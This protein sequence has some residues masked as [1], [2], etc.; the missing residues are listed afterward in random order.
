MYSQCRD[1]RSNIRR[2]KLMPDAG[3]RVSLAIPARGMCST[4]RLSSAAA[5]AATRRFGPRDYPPRDSSGAGGHDPRARRELARGRLVPQELSICS[6]AGPAGLGDG[7]GNADGSCCA[8]AHGCHES[9]RLATGLGSAGGSAG[10]LSASA[11]R[12]C[13]T[14]CAIHILVGKLTGA[15]TCERVRERAVSTSGKPAKPAKRSPTGTTSK[16]QF[17]PSCREAS[18]H[19]RKRI[20]S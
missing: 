11:A 20:S 6:R 1:K 14:L 17:W 16:A 12:R 2:S 15:S 4:T 13:T 5:P 19:R 7:Y 8:H 9:V 3:V 10:T 18:I